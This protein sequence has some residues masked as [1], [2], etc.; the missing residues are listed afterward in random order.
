MVSMADVV[1]GAKSQEE[2]K[3]EERKETKR[4]E[5]ETKKMT[6]QKTR[7]KGRTSIG[8]K[9]DGVGGR[10]TPAAVSSS[11]VLIPGRGAWGAWQTTRPRKNTQGV[12]E[13]E[14]EEEA[15]GGGGGKENISDDWY[16][17]SSARCKEP[18][19]GFGCIQMG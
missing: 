3:E 12:E 18:W 19:G 14:E 6:E 10:R 1:D 4:K 9:S 8:E 16:C 17:R 5:E 15:S 7:V 13:E 2:R 11:K